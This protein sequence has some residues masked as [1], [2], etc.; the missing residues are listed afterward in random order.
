MARRLAGATLAVMLAAGMP[1]AG[2]AQSQGTGSSGGPSQP[3]QAAGAGQAKPALTPAQ[4]QTLAD[5]K[6]ELQV[7]ARQIATLKAELVQTGA[8]TGAAGGGDALQRMDAIEAELTRLTA[9]TEEVDLRLRKVVADGTNRIGDIEFR[10]CDMKPGCD[11][12]KLP[13]TPVLGGAELGPSPTPATPPA[14]TDQGGTGDMAVNE[15]SDFDA[16]KKAFDAGDYAKA[17]TLFATFAKTYTG[18]KL[19]QQA[20]VLRGDALDQTG[21][22]ANSARAYLQAFSGQPKGPLAGQALTKLGQQLGKLGQTHE[23]CVTLTEVGRRFPGTPDA[24]NAAA[25]MQ[26]LGCP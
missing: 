24:G 3:G 11:P 1:A 9:K 12:T 26:S 17:A 22:V 18:G 2:L 16:A 19:T 25:A 4:L 14:T 5:V 6:A 21:D 23:A 13:A 10:L 8:A 15:Q 20:L 7:L